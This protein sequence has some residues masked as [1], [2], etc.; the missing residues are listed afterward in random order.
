MAASTL[1]EQHI[2]GG[3]GTSV[4]DP[5][6]SGEADD[7]VDAICL[8]GEFYWRD[9]TKS[10]VIQ[11]AVDIVPKDRLSTLK[12]LKP[13]TALFTTAMAAANGQE[14]SETFLVQQNRGRNDLNAL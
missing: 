10:R 14:H 11:G 8:E 13:A 3:Y 1:A 9:M 6:I 2:V 5:A 12:S 7:M 4:S